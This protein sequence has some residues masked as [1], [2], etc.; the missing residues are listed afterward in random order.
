[1]R[2]SDAEA[3]LVGFAALERGS[4][5]IERARPVIGS[6]VSSLLLVH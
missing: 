4:A 3:G 5:C 6:I 1:M 2:A